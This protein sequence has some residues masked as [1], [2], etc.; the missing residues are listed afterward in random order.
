MIA[1]SD[2]TREVLISA[3]FVHLK[4]AELL[5]HVRNL[6]AASH[7]ILLSGPTGSFPSCAG[8]WPQEQQPP[9][10]AACVWAEGTVATC[11]PLFR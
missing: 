9:P 2:Q 3:A 11:I 4:N 7:A 1:C 10:L 5:K 8:P 6:S